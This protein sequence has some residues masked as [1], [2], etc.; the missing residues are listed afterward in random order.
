MKSLELNWIRRK[1]D[2]SIPMPDVMFYPLADASGRYYPPKNREMYDFNGKPYHMRYGVIVIN[3]EYDNIDST[4]AH[5]WR[6][7]WQHF[8]GIKFEISSLTMFKELEYNESLLK[9]FTESKTELDALRFEY[10]YAGIHDGWEE[11]LHPILKDLII[12]PIITYGNNT[13]NNR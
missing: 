13:F 2:K 5:E 10:K 3:P 9:Y 1:C 6:H 7:H 8:H 12:K 11:I 4:I